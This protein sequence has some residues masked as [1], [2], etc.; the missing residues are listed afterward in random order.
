MLVAL[1]VLLRVSGFD[2]DYGYAM[3]RCGVVWFGLVWLW[4]LNT[5]RR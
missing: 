5:N 1:A 4:L 3:L 2:Y